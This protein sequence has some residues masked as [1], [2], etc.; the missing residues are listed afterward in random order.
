MAANAPLIVHSS[1]GATADV[2]HLTR[3]VKEV[4]VKNTHATQS[5]SLKVFTGATSAAAVA[6]ATANATVAGAN[7]TFTIP[8]G[9]TK[10]VFKSTRQQY[11]AANMIGTG[12]ATTFDMEGTIWTTGS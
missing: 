6:T 3:K 12:A 7:D 2:F 1:V 8:A 10:T 11:V 4:V 9:A 5:I